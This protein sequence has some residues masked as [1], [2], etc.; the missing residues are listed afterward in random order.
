VVGI[1]SADY[2]ILIEQGIFGGHLVS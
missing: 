1:W 2:A